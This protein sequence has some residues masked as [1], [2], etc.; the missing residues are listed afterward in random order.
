MSDCTVPRRPGRTD[1]IIQS[2]LTGAYRPWAFTMD[3]RFGRIR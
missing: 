3:A 2:K 1:P